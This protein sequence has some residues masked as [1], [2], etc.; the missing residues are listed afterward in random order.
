[1]PNETQQKEFE[2]GSNMMD[3]NTKMPAAI[4]RFPGRAFRAML[5]ALTLAAV[6]LTFSACKSKMNAT[7]MTDWPP[8]RDLG[9]QTAAELESVTP[10]KKTAPVPAPGKEAP[11]APAATT[12]TIR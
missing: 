12:V 5:L 2:K 3:H 9:K 1:M 11:P 7:P 8:Y 6:T 10:K 4:R